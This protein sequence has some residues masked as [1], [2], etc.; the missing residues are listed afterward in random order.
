MRKKNSYLVFFLLL[1]TL[2]GEKTFA[3]ADDMAIWRT[4]FEKPF[5][6]IHSADRFLWDSIEHKPA[7]EVKAIIQGLEGDEE[8]NSSDENIAKIYLLKSIYCRTYDSLYGNEG[9]RFWG[10]KSLSLARNIDN[11]Y[12]ME[13]CYLFL[14]DAYLRR[15]NYD[16]AVF[17]LLK[18]AELSEK[19]G[20]REEFVVS[21][22]IAISNVLYRTQ[23]YQQCINFC[24]TSFDIESKLEPITVITAYN[25]AGLCY[26]KLN[27]PDSAIYYFN[28]VAVYAHKVKWGLWEG[29]AFGNIGDALHEKA[30]DEKAM[31]YWQKDYDSSMKYK[32][33]GNAALTLAYISEYE[34]NDGQRSKAI[35]Q[36]QWAATV[37]QEDPANL[38]T[39]YKIISSCYRK[40][41]LHDSAYYFL[42]AHYRLID[43][44]NQVVSRNKYNLVELHLAFEKSNYEFTIL[45]KER[46]AEIA[47]RNLLLVALLASL[48]AALLLYN[49]EHLKAKLAKQKSET[50]EAEKRSAHE[51]LQTF[52]E[53]LLEKNEQIEQLTSSLEQQTSS[54]VDELIHQSLLTD[55]DWKRFKD[56]FEKTYPGFFSSLREIAPG[57]TQS[58]MRLAALMRLNLGNKEMA[59]IQGISVSSLRGNKTRLRQKLDISGDTDLEDFM[60]QL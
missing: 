33:W 52:T 15:N 6:K 58:E 49:R 27:K 31:P 4:L 53:I 5:D 30:E 3:Q 1:L 35:K 59:S 56:L 22:K 11:D 54:N 29:I 14:G 43:S 9:W 23:N 8:V 38:M 42:D 12:I 48:L 19:L 20:Y 16:T 51:Q 34:F 18:T 25:N 36:L 28:K 47:R 45:R 46:K 39:I 44:M 40:L 37:E 17:Y 10:N 24:V 32:E 7:A 50:A 21:N 57:I 26:W 41:N 60:K 55:S 2:A 13:G